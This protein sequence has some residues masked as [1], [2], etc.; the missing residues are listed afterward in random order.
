MFPKMDHL[1][2]ALTSL[3]SGTIEIQPDSDEDD[4]TR[5][6]YVFIPHSDSLLLTLELL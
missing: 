6:K 2:Y 4:Y 3:T 5:V 1:S